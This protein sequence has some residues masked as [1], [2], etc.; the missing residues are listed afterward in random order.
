MSFNIAGFIKKLLP[1]LD[2]SDIEDDMQIS[3]ESISTITEVY[4]DLEQ[5]LKV[6]AFNSK[7]NKDILKEFY[8]ELKLT[9]V[10]LSP[11][12]NIATDTLTIF[13]NIK[14]NGEF[15]SKEVSD[16]L[17]DVIVSQAL[18]AVKT[19]LI[20]A[21]AHYYFISKFALDLS[22][23]LYVNE[24]ENG[25]YELTSDF[26][27]NKKEKELIVSNVWIY[28]RL[29]S[30]YGSDPTVFMDKL[31]SISEITLPKDRVDDAIDTYSSDN[32][33]LFNN[34]PEGFIGSPIYSI[35]LMFATWEAD[36]YL[37]L[38]NKK[39]LLE[40][41]YLH[42]KMLQENGQADANMEKDIVYLQKR[43]TDIQYKL[44]KIEE[45]VE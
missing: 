43:C 15:I 31:K 44:T 23:L 6:F 29:L 10:R 45:S 9:K 21:V 17:N 28:A 38:K 7:E 26:K 22:N 27:L 35:R 41:R 14:T 3:M 8:K 4:T 2:K 20:R 16:A 34:L 36:R 42:L 12:E 1:S 37:N 40:L 18:T 19:N 33:D 5:V 32:I 25:K 30:V 13:K 39:K 11:R 24:A